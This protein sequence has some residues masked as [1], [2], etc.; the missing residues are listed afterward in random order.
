LPYEK[1][2]W[3]GIPDLSKSITF[4]QGTLQACDP[5]RPL[6]TATPWGR[7]GFNHPRL[8]DDS[9]GF[10]VVWCQ[11]CLSYMTD[12]DLVAF[13]KRSQRTLRKGGA[14]VV[15]ENVCKDGEGGVPENRFDP[16]DF[17]RNTVR[18]IVYITF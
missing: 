2:K 7:F 1:Q 15:K 12:P 11:W 14:I 10:D 8:L 18:F 16:V 13:L 17:K 3:R 6:R 9:T 4:L 5:A